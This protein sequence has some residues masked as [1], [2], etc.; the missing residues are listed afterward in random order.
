MKGW[1]GSIPFIV[2]KFLI[3]IYFCNKKKKKK[4][5]FIITDEEGSMT[6]PPLLN[7]M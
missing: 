2:G 6:I 4:K 7:I 3:I 5:T 1:Y